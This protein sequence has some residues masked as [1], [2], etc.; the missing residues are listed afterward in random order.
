M[1]SSIDYKKE[2]NPAQLEAVLA[3]EGPFLVIAGA[4]SGK[5]R[6]LVFRTAHLVEK[7]V[8]PERILLLTFT[9]RASREMLKRAEELLD[10]RCSQ[11]SGGTF[12]SFANSIRRR[13]AEAVNLPRFFSILDQ[14]DA[15]NAVNLVRTQMSKQLDKRF[16]KKNTLLGI[17][18]KSV[19]KGISVD[20]VVCEEYPQFAEWSQVIEH[21]KQEYIRY[22]HSLAL[23]DYDDLLVYL[24]QLLQNNKEIRETLSQYYQYIMVDEYQDTNKI[25]AEIVRLLASTH[26][27]VMVVGDDSQSIYS[28]RGAHFKNIIDYPRIFTG[29]KVITLEENYRSTQPI[30]DLTNEVINSAGEKFD[31]AL[32]TRNGGETLPVY[33]DVYNENSQSRYIVKKI[34][35]LMNEGVNLGEI[36]IL[37]RSGWHSND[38]EVELA[39]SGIPFVKYGGQKFIEAAHIKDILSCLQIIYNPLSEIA[40]Q[41][42]LM[43]VKGVGEK[44]AMQIIEEIVRQR[45]GLEIDEKIFQKKPELKQLFKILKDIDWTVE[46]P[47]KILKSVLDFYTPLLMDHYDDYEKRLNDL[48]SLENIAQRYASLEE[49][50]TDMALEPPEKTLVDKGQKTHGENDLIL[51]TIHSAKGLEWHTVFLIYLA[52]GYLP[53]YQSMSSDD[54]I[55]EERRLFYVAATR[56]KSNL[57]LLRPQIDTSPR[58]TWD[59]SGSMYTQ[60]SR[61]LE[62][63]GILSK[64]VTM[65]TDRSGYN[66][67][68]SWEPKQPKEQKEKFYDDW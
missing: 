30:L 57:Y 52:E 40:W 55:E 22:K 20:D 6:V 58:R 9:R 27:N 47:V 4:G 33:V 23:L 66:P 65:E 48:A 18:S 36:A 38:L 13:Y 19:N 3:T 43:L 63:G 26:N 8:A 29:T 12:H 42:V 54:A 1:F 37:F 16:P 44:T 35:N 56:A 11:V 31:K 45:K 61:F 51:S 15:E 2:L 39:S 25:Q 14:D 67:F 5:T 17:I 50:L 49:F 21:M 59:T 68:R 64:Y 53:S 28:F 32:F 46:A 10:S 41:R 7:G 62:E 24:R 60:V 34:V